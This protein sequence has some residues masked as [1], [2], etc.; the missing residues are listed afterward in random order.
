MTE[1]T[2]LTMA[3]KFKVIEFLDAA[4]WSG[5]NNY[6]C[7]NYSHAGELSAGQKLLTHF[8]GYITDRQTPFKSIFEIGDYVFSDLAFCYSA[9]EPAD[10]LLSP[11]GEKSFFKRDNDGKWAFQSRTKAGNN[12]VLEYN[13]FGQD[14]AVRFASR[15]IS[16]DYVAVFCVLKTLEDRRFD[17][18]LPQFA[19]RCME[20]NNEHPLLLNVLYGLYLLGYSDMGIWSLNEGKKDVLDSAAVAQRAETSLRAVDEFFSTGN[21]PVSYFEKGKLQGA[22]FESKRVTCFL[23]DLIKFHGTSA[24]DGFADYFEM[25]LNDPRRFADLQSQLHVLELPGDVWNNNNRFYSCLFEATREE[26]QFKESCMKPGSKSGIKL[27]K[28]LRYI[29]DEIGIRDCYPEQFDVTFDFARNMCAKPNQ[30]NCMY[31]PFGVTSP[32]RIPKE[33]CHKAPDKYC[34]FLL[35]ACGYKTKCSEVRAFCPNYRDIPMMSTKC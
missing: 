6:D 32:G 24:K 3:E 26:S 18:S 33:F 34:P 35:Y 15:F 22:V 19:R 31:C 16:T 5:F 17:R 13:G 14:D 9:G 8:L 1:K 23:R 29:Y 7:P 21:I 10:E 27:N 28:L 12:P 20:V 11:D 2:D 4:R 30:G 25:E